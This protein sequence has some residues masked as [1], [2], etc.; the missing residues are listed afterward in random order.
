MVLK[1]A[2][3][4]TGLLRTF[5]K[6]IS[7]FKTNIIE[8]NHNMG[9]QVD[10]FACIHDANHELVTEQLFHELGSHLVKLSWFNPQ[11]LLFQQVQ[12]M[13]L[14]NMYISDPWKQYLRTSGSMIEYYQLY[15][16]NLQ[17]VKKEQIEHFHYD[18]VIRCRPDVVITK[19]IDFSWLSLSLNDLRLRVKNLTVNEI[20]HF[21][22]TLIDPTR[23]IGERDVTE[24]HNSQLLNSLTTYESL[25]DFLKNGR[26]IL[27]LRKNVVYI[28]KRQFF[29]PIASLGVT[30][31]LTQQLDNDYWFN[32]ESQ[33]QNTCLNNN[34]VIFDSTTF[35]EDNSLYH[36]ETSNYFDSNGDLKDNN[37]LFFICRS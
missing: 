3:L 30:Y 24:C 29:Y 34:L 15:S 8:T 33:L 12:N 5:D 4:Y 14:N 32:A 20:H 7:Y 23:T 11:D 21:F 37:C 31:G 16:A 26:Y 17:M 25:L 36:Y 27:T 9:H 2:V 10:V 28:V 6:T 18:Y 22:N 19:P 1:I 13:L 35:L